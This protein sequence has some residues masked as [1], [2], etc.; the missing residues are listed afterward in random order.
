VA[1][2]EQHHFNP[3]KHGGLQHAEEIFHSETVKISKLQYTEN[4]VQFSL[5]KGPIKTPF[6][7]WLRSMKTR[8]TYSASGKVMLYHHPYRCLMQWMKPDKRY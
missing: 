3:K 7:I 2:L 8:V 5:H 4:F 6:G 1:V